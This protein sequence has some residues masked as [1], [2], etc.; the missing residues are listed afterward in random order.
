VR[1][2]NFGEELLDS[3]FPSH[4]ASLVEVLAGWSTTWEEIGAPG[5]N[6]SPPAK[7]LAQAFTAAGWIEQ[8]FEVEIRLNGTPTIGKSH[9]VD[10]FRE[11]APGD[12][13]PGIAAD[14]EWSNKDEFFDRDL[15]NF[16]A[17][18]AARGIAVAILICRSSELHA[19]MVRRFGSQ[20][21]GTR[22]THWDKL[23]PR[24]ELGRGGATPLIAIGIGPERVRG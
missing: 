17:L 21:F 2:V 12:P 6:L 13:F 22:T 8:A 11:K 15:I 5:G 18:H 24:L 16:E 7:S 9:K 20:R 4:A 14:T 10:H 1:N 3:A 19:E 23:M